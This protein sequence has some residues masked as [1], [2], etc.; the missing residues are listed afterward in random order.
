VVDKKLCWKPY[1]RQHASVSKTVTPG[2]GG[3]GGDRWV[4][5]GWVLVGFKRDLV[6]SPVKWVAV[7]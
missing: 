2:G 5:P 7:C 6:G 4:S 3:R 1:R